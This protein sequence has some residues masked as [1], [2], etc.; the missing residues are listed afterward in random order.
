M[1][2]EVIP[3][4][5]DKFL[6]IWYNPSYWYR[7]E[8]TQISGYFSYKCKHF[9]EKANSYLFFK[10]FMS[11]ISQ[12]ITKLKQSICQRDIFGGR[13]QILLSY[14]TK[15]SKKKNSVLEIRYLQFSILIPPQG[16]KNFHPKKTF[17][18][19]DYFHL[20]AVK[21]QKT[22]GETLTSPKNVFKKLD[23]GSVPGIQL[24]HIQSIWARCGGGRAQWV[25]DH[26]L[27]HFLYMAQ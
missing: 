13:G 18:H 27:S 8:D 2:I 16:R 3:F 6:E 23:R 5:I 4:S 15:H 22:Q 25:R 26:S 11:V 24:S 10:F 1:E 21:S 19:A 9:L 12:K 17:W 20:K 14:T 7:I